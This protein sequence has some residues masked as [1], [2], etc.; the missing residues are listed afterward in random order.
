METPNSARGVKRPPRGAGTLSSLDARPAR[1]PPMKLTTRHDYLDRV[2]RV[3]R[4]AQE[5]LD[6]PLA[7]ERLADVAHLSVYHF[8]RIFS[9]LVGESL[10]DH[11]RRLRLERAAGELRRTDRPVIDVALGAGYDSHEAFTRAFKDRFG[12][13]PSAYRRS[14]GPLVIPRALCG[15]H[16]GTDEAVS[17]FVP[18]QEDSRMIDV[19]IDTQP[20]RRLLALA[21]R[22][23]YLAIGDAFARVFA[24]AG[25]RGLVTADTVSLGIYYDDPDIVPLDALR[26]HACV[27]VP[28]SCAD[29]PDGFELIDLAGS[30]FAVGV[31]RGPY[32]QLPESYRWLF[33]QWLPASGR[34]PANRPCHEIYVTDPQTTP[35]ERLITHICLPL[36]VMESAGAESPA[37][38]ARLTGDAV[39]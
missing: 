33:G 35:A 19:R 31:H 11:V 37:V 29:A 7:P 23:D 30:E 21:H 16:Y 6:E 18:L 20:P 28:A 9:G 2:R 1:T 38:V 12:A 3:L 5:H 4:Y 32:E 39:S 22:G 15:V 25:R 27:T 10:G 36:V 24:E 8:H 26:S 14:D 13:P 34:E 17:G